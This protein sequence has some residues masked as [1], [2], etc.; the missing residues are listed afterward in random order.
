MALR[1]D[2]GVTT[3]DCLLSERDNLSNPDFKPPCQN[4]AAGFQ[5]F[6]YGPVGA[7]KQNFSWFSETTHFD[8]GAFGSGCISQ[9]PFVAN[10]PPGGGGVQAEALA[11]ASALLLSNTMYQ[12]NG[13]RRS[14]PLQ[15]RQIIV[16]ISNGKPQVD[17]LWGS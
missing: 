14:T 3:C 4:L 12:L 5:I 10:Q 16:S 6:E 17:N 1:F 15:N 2:Q 13:F 8:K 11:L 7:C 9:G